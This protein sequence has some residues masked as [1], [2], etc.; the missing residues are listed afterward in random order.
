L[1]LIGI[2]LE[3]RHNSSHPLFLSAVPQMYD[4]SLWALLVADFVFL[5]GLIWYSAG[6]RPRVFGL[7]VIQFTLCCFVV[8]GDFAWAAGPP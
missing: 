6:V 7:A 2:P 8:Y 3:G 1:W 5:T 4:W